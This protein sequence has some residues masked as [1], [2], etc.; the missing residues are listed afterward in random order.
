MSAMTASDPT[1]TDPLISVVGLTVTYGTGA[2]A[3]TALDGVDLE[4]R[5]GERIAVVGESGSGKSTLVAAMLGLLPSAARVLGGEIRVDGTVLDPRRPQTRLLGRVVGYVPQDPLTNLD[6]LRR[7]GPQVTS[8]ARSHGLVTRNEA[9][10][11]AVEALAHAGVAEPETRV[12]QYPHEL[13]GGLRQRSLIA[14]ATAARPAVL[15]ADEPTSALDVTVQ[16][17]ILDRLEQLVAEDHLALVFVTHDLA[18]A[19]ERADRLVVMRS[20]RV[21][22]T[23]DAAAVL[24]EPSHPYTRAL[25]AAVPSLVDR[26]PPDPGEPTGPAVLSGRDLVKDY[27]GRR[28]LDGASFDVHA[29][30]TLAVVGES[31]SGKS[32]LAQIALRLLTP[33]SGTVLFEGADVTTADRAGLR[34]LRRAVQP[35]FQDPASSLDPT[36]TVARAVAEPLRVSKASTATVRRRVRELLDLVSIPAA[37]ADRPVTALSGGQQQ[38]VAIAR[39]LALQPRVLICDEPV[40]ALDVLVQEQILELFT[41]LQQELGLAY[42]FISHDLAVVRRLAHDVL[43]M[44]GGRVV[45]S[46]PARAVLDAPQADY[47]RELLAAVPRP[48]VA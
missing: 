6:P 26:R 44:H 5:A 48:R 13:S 41:T 47:T 43:V 29:G 25:L 23:G 15:L 38:R 16:R 12:S 40:S 24:R 22:E 1:P 34:E 2:E 18:L 19:A 42:L 8:S 17:R 30:H 39:A 33:T 32:T 46:G 4:V 35:V 31:G 10:A 3:H 21:V 7:I 28:A 11:L 37:A 20:G 9:P 45:E 27:P 36:F 14:A